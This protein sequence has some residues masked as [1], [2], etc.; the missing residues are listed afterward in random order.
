MPIEFSVDIFS[1]C[2]I[3]LSTFQVRVFPLGH[4][5]GLSPILHD[6]TKLDNKVVLALIAQ[7]SSGIFSLFLKKLSI[8]MNKLMAITNR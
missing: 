4:H 5:G 8:K 2:P 1:L 7:E 3:E 6:L